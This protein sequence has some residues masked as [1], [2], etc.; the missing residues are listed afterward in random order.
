MPNITASCTARARPSR[1]MDRRETAP[2]ET[3]IDRTGLRRRNHI[4][5]DAMP[6]K[7]PN[8]TTYDSGNFTKSVEQSSGA[9]RL[10]RLCGRK[11][12]SRARGRPR[13]RDISDYLELTGPSGRE[14]G[15]IRFES[16]DAITIIT[17][18]LDYG[19]GNASPFAQVLST[20]LGIPFSDAL[21]VGSGTGGS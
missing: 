17:G 20:R 12:K 8:G 5:P 4:P 19:Q 15:G 9:C 21:I 11:A 14:T 16:D 18:T 13:G 3:G 1:Q 7:A 6:W 10:G 2:A